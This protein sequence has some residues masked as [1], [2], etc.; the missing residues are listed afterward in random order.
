MML[1]LRDRV[2]RSDQVDRWSVELKDR[3]APVH[4]QNV[5]G[6][7]S[8]ELLRHPDHTYGVHRFE[9]ELARSARRRNVDVMQLDPPPKAARHFQYD[10]SRRSILP[11]AF[12]M[13]RSDGRI[14]AFF[15]EYERS[16]IY[17]SRMPDKLDSYLAYYSTTRPLDEH[18]IMPITLFVFETAFRAERFTDVARGEIQKAGAQLPLWVSSEE[19]LYA[20]DPFSP[21]WRSPYGNQLESPLY[22][23]V[24]S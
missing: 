5:A 10:R 4:W 16:A 14:C 6:R 15:L 20:G 18:G 9:A 8:A 12:G 7:N 2:S 22:D 21:V 13:L 17:E 3:E 19:E 23:A 24:L 11:D 1:A